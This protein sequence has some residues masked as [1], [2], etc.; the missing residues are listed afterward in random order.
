VKILH[1]FSNFKFTGPADPALVL[2]KAQKNLGNEVFFCCGQAPA[3]QP[4]YLHDI[5]RD[6]G[7]SL[8]EDFMLPKHFQF[9]ALIKD[10]SKLRQWIEIESPDVLHCHLPGDHLTASLARSSRSPIVIKSH[11]QL[12]PENTI[13]SAFCRKHTD[14]WIAPTIKSA[15]DL[16]KCGIPEESILQLA[17]PVDLTRF[18]P[19]EEGAAS[20]DHDSKIRVGVVAR[21][22]RN[23][24]FPELIEAF[25]LAASKDPRL[26]LEILGRGTNQ[27]E[28]AR[29]PANRSSVKHRI[30]FPGYIEPSSYPARLK[31]FD[32]LVFL[33]PGSD[34]T[35]RAA[36]EALSCGIPVIA[37]RRG[38]LPELIPADGGILL[39]HENPSAL[40]EAILELSENRARRREM[41]VNARKFVELHSSPET[42]AQTLESAIQGNFR[43]V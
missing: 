12:H 23:R 15:Q 41:G 3:D 36:R 40:S 22:Q 34:G 28:V 38:L 6:R 11:Y 17:P 7:F 39:D 16:T 33:V 9:S 30:H 13:R 35:C 37:S 2:A 26:E 5:A 43:A 27:N 14:L 31:R 24:K 18:S 32:M 20:L 10:V 25:S 29:E 19:P 4:R 21:M 1:L 8:L 42:I